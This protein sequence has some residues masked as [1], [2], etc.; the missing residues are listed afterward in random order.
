MYSVVAAQPCCTAMASVQTCH[1]LN[2]YSSLWNGKYNKG[3]A[4]LMKSWNS[5]SNNT[6]KTFYFPKWS[7]HFPNANSLCKRSDDATWWQTCSNPNFLKS[8]C[9]YQIEH[10]CFWKIKI[11]DFSVSVFDKRL[12]WF[13]VSLP[14]ILWCTFFT[15]SALCFYI[16]S[17]IFFFTVT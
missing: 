10:I 9:W 2:T 5:D 12:L 4:T 3:N 16:L 8:C 1:S 13:Y 7:P 15:I 11:K 6:G 17:T 14:L